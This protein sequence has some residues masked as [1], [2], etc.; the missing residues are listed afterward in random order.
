MTGTRRLFA[1]SLAALMM[2]LSPLAG[3]AQARGSMVSIARAEVHMRDGPGTRHDALWKLSAGYP[4]QVIGQ[5]G[6]W[7]RVRDFEADEGWVYR[8]LVGKTPH[9]VVKAEVANLRSG[10]STR[11]RVIARLERGE[12]LRTLE[13]QPRWVKVRQQDGTKGWVARRLLW[14]W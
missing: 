11:T 13:R 4:L 14:G 7:L 9:H 6:R 2:T 8:S 12:V 1:A 5:Q 3:W 10:P